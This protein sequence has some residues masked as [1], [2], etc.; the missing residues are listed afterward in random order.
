[1]TII[2]GQQCLMSSTGVLINQESVGMLP[3]S[4]GSGDKALLQDD[5]AHAERQCFPSPIAAQSES[6]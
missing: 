6:Q 2:Q 5:P 4:G 3:E 1:M